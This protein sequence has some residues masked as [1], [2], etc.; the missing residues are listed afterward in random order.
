VFGLE[1]REAFERMSGPRLMKKQ[2]TAAKNNPSMNAAGMEGRPPK[3]ASAMEN[4][5]AATGSQ[6]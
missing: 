1:K 6:T 2:K 4:A 3:A 5:Q